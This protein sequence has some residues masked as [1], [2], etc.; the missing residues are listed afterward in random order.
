MIYIDLFGNPP[1]KELI[2]EGKE[3]TKQLMAVAP[4]ERSTFIKKHASYWGKL[5]EHYSNL[6]N[7]KCWYSESEDSASIYHM[8]HF[9][10]KNETMALIQNCD[11]D[12][13]NNNEP[14]WWLAFNW[15]NYRF[16]ASIPNTSKNS[17][18]P[19]QI[20][21]PIAKNEAELEKEWP[22]LLDPTDE[23]DVSLI[24]YGLDGKVYPA[25]ADMNCWDAQRVVLSTRVYNLN[26][27]S[28][29]DKRKEIQQMCKTKI[30]LIKDAQR[31]YAKTRSPSFRRMLKQYI[32]EL[33]AMTKPTSELSSVARNYIRNDP[34]EFIRNIAG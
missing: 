34:E 8:D 27:V 12:T 23:F 21:S 29:V 16:A 14:Y 20:G 18:F 28:L 17:Y 31:E 2:D 26:Y 24:A 6:S 32:S 11:I 9:R 22:G 7:G 30:D 25:C 4:D 3:L 13:A 10:P 15:K 5:K 1:S 19:L 33:R